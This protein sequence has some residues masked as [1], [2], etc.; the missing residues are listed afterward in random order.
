MQDEQFLKIHQRLRD[1]YP[2]LDIMVVSDDVGCAHFKTVAQHHGIACLF[3]K[4]YSATFMGD[5][6][7]ILGGRYHYALRGADRIGPRSNGG[8]VPST[9]CTEPTMSCRPPGTPRVS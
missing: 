1:L 2:A 7:L 9:S 4:D 8:P 6:A 5:G 3:S